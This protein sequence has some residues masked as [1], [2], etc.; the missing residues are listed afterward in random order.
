MRTPVCVLSKKLTGRRV[1]RSITRRRMSVM[2]RCAVMLITCERANE[3][4]AC[5]SVTPSSPAARGTRRP[6]RCF[7]ITSSTM[8]RVLAGSTS[9]A[10]REI[11][12]STLPMAR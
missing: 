11:S 12:I 8:K 10:A 1:T 9:P 4:A 3:A 5:S 7:P 2:A 6:V